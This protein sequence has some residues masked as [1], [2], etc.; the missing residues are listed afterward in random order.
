MAPSA[1]IVRQEWPVVLGIMLV[2]ELAS[3][4]GDTVSITRLGYRQVRLT[5]PAYGAHRESR[6]W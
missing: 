6:R 3:E 1:I 5:F 4:D 2:K